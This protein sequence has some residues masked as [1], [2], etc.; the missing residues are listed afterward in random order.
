M[1]QANATTAKKYAARNARVKSAFTDAKTWTSR[2]NTEQM[3]VVPDDWN[4]TDLEI[5]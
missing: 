5:T 4:F 2:A 3:V 1:Q